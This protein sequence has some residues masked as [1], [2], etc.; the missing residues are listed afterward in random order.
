MKKAL[1]IAG[2]LALSLTAC[3]FGK[4]TPEGAMV[5]AKSVA[6]AEGKSPAAIEAAGQKAYVDAGGFEEELR[7]YE[8]FKGKKGIKAPKKPDWYK[9]EVAAE[10][11]VEKAAAPV[12]EKVEEVKEVKEAAK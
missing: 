7:I 8:K 5:V 11:V 1:L 6:K 10:P 9:A 12:V 2:M 3:K 4:N